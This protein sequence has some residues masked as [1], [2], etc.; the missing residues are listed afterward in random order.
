[1]IISEK[2]KKS[3]LKTPLAKS[4]KS[5]ESYLNNKKVKGFS[6]SS[7]HNN[8][9][10]YCIS[11]YKTGTT[12]LSSGFNSD[13]VAHEP[14][15]YLSLLKL[16]ENF[17]E[18]FVR[19]LNCLDLKLECSGYL[20]AYIDEIK[21]N[22]ISADLNYICIIRKPSD[23]VSS[24]LNYWGKLDFLKFDYIND[25]FWNKKVGVD[26]INFKDKTKEEQEVIINKLADF[27]LKFT[28]DTF[29]L[30][31]IKHVQ[32]EG[33]EEYMKNELSKQIDENFSLDKV[34]RRTN[35]NK[36]NTYTLKKHDADYYEL[37]N[38]NGN[39]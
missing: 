11:P 39:V 16:E 23:W 6:N 9:T 26:L 18:F 27:Y 5:L 36:T 10:Y 30:K 28:K 19:K 17:D 4:L 22:S 3:L 2:I 37:I 12:F 14:M 33:L 38:N 29:S 7:I 1:M 8:K 35:S 25:L 20:S 24:V 31:N 32:I 34:Y 21:K 15:Q 13:L